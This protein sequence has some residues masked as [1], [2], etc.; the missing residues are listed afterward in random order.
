MHYDKTSMRAMSRM[1]VIL[2]CQAA[3]FA[4]PFLTWFTRHT[5]RSQK[6]NHREYNRELGLRLLTI[7]S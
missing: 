3:S 5:T 2:P 1:D 4:L 6:T 7:S